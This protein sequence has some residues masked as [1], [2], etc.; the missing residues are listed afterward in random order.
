MKKI[1]SDICSVLAMIAIA[2]LFIGKSVTFAQVAPPLGQAESFAVLAGSAV[3]N[4]GST[5]IIGDLGVSPGT[6]ITGF[7]PGTV[8]GGTIHTNDAV[9]VQAQSDLTV[10]YNNL[11]GQPYNTDLTGQ[12]LGGLTLTSGVYHFS[13]SAQLTGTLTLNAQGS[14]SSVFIFQIGSTLTTASNSHVI[15][16]N[17]GSNCKVFWQI[18]SSAT[19]GTATAFI[20]NIFALASITLTTGATTS[21]RVLAR[22]G[23]V[24]LDNSSVSVCPACSPIVISPGTLP[25]GT[26]GTLYNQTLVASGGTVPYNYE[27]ISGLPPTGLTLSPAGVLSGSPSTAGSFTFTVTATDDNGCIGSHIYTIVINPAGCPPI[28]VSPLTLPAMTAGIPYNQSITATGGTGPYTFNVTSGI[29]P[30]GV[31]LSPAGL[32]SGTTSVPGNYT[33]TITATDVLSCAGSRIYT[34]MVNP[35]VVPNIPTL[36]EWGLII[37]GFVILGIGT[38]YIVRRNG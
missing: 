31:T 24:T 4:T 17:G 19:L 38:L 13:S 20:G 8:T 12:D 11:A 6:A 33:F 7:P 35:V 32:L 22:N 10:A 9:A 5:I 26:V 27:V 2:I 14:S 18:G 28:T 15:M 3:T 30:Q 16:I 36:S 23:A 1:T 29:L 37:L 25:N 21:G 34:M